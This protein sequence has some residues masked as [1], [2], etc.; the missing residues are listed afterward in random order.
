MFLLFTVFTFHPNEIYMRM[1]MFNK[2]FTAKT[3]GDTI[4]SIQSTLT[5]NF[6]QIWFVE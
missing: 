2:R 3:T 4:L 6:Y 5:L 1:F